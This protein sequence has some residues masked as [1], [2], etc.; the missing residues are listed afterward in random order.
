MEYIRT[1]LS[2]DGNDPIKKENLII[3]EREDESE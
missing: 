1:C 2:V 3:T